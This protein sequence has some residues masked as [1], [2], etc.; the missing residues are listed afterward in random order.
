MALH[1]LS[2]PG[3]PSL[4]AQMTMR[5]LQLYATAKPIVVAAPAGVDQIMAFTKLGGVS[6]NGGLMVM[7]LNNRDWISQKKAVEPG[8]A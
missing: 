5:M 8:N 4:V 2:A 1:S 6:V 3:E 7:P